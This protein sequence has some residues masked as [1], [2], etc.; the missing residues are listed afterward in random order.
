[1]IGVVGEV[2]PAV[3]AAFGAGERLGWIDIDLGMT[4]AAPR[5]PATMEPTSRFPA[6][7]V[8]LAFVVPDAVPAAAVDATLRRSAGELLERLELFDV[9]RGGQLAAGHRS[10]AYRLRLRASDRTLTDAEVA[11]L[12]ANCIDAVETAHHAALRG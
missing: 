10:L 6:S 4:L 5:R 9:F 2:D 1:V 3:V 8:D 7:D 12:R 11:A